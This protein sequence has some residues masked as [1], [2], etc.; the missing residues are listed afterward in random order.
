M[1][2][3]ATVSTSKIAFLFCHQ[4]DTVAASA[5]YVFAAQR[6]GVLDLYG[7]QALKA[8]MIASEPGDLCS[9]LVSSADTSQPCLISKVLDAVITLTQKATKASMASH[10]QTL[11]RNP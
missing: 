1:T 8:G 10:L 3:L 7:E 4:C 6:K 11:H 5:F 2:F 9:L